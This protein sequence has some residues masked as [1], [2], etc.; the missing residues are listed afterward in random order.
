MNHVPLKLHLFFLLTLA[1]SCLT[2]CRN[3]SRA[4]RQTVLLDQAGGTI[5]FSSGEQV[6]VAAGFFDGPTAVSATLSRD[7]PALG[8]ASTDLTSLRRYSR[9]AAPGVTLEFSADAVAQPTSYLSNRA[10]QVQFPVAEPGD[11]NRETPQAE[12]LLQLADGSEHLYYSPLDDDSRVRLVNG[13][14]LTEE[15]R[16]ARVRLSVSPVRLEP[17]AN[18]ETQALPSG[19]FTEEVAGPFQEGVGFAFAPDERI[20][21]AEKRGVVRVVQGGTLLTAPFIDIAAQ[22]NSQ[23]DRGLLSVA[24]HPDFPATP[25]VYLLHTYEPPQVQGSGPGGADGDGGRVARLVRV[26]A[27][28][29]RNHNVALAGSE[30]ILLG[31]NSSYANIGNPNQRNSAVPS[32]EQDGQ[33][34]RDC[35][36]SDE[37]S[38]TIGSLR[39][40]S[41]GALLVSNGDGANFLAVEPYATRSLEL[42]SLAGKIL[43]IDPLTGRGLADNPFYDGDP[44]SN[45]SK[46]LSLGL[47]NPFRFALQPGTDTPFVGDVGWSTWEEINAG[48]GAN[49]GWPCYEGGVA[50]NLEQGSYRAL[51]R[52][53]Q[54]YTSGGVT[55][56]LYAYPHDGLSASAQVGDFYTGDSY[57]SEYK[58]AL[59]IADYSA[60]WIK[61]L[62]LTPAGE[63]ESVHDFGS[64]PGVVQLTQAP[65]G[66][67]YYMNI[68]E[69]RLKRIRFSSA[70]NAAPSARINADPRKGG[71]PLVVTFSGAASSDPDDDALT[72]SWTFGDGSTATGVSPSHTYTEPGVYTAQLTVTDP[73]TAT[74]TARLTVEV[75]ESPPVATITAPA[76]GARYNVGD[77]VRYNGAGVDPED[78]ALTGAG[79]QWHFLIHHADH[80]HFDALPATSVTPGTFTPPDHG[81]NSYMELCLTVTDS[82]GAQDQDCHELYPNLARYTLQTEPP[83]LSLSWEGRERQTPFSVETPV[84]SKHLLVA[85]TQQGAWTFAGWS[86]GGERLHSLTVE[87]DKTLTARY[88]LNE[89]LLDRTGN[90][91]ETE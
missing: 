7:L 55:A 45:R 52:C 68:V 23:W 41:S 53:Q 13:Q 36:P 76:D 57:P 73:N 77:T 19:F 88:T 4:D 91:C 48:R 69:G 24:V 33:Y 5:S 65:N 81:D 25:Y 32:C 61:Y 43:R 62:R 78:G 2:A 12:V 16:G 14:L 84:G 28:P 9:A 26:S 46:V 70:G 80:L 63:L 30:V 72:Y 10:L 39:F 17:A 21:I 8:A 59:F 54:L 44:N 47:R 71:V 40:S 82:Q 35:L 83:G 87:D 34:V 74:G 64:E 42:D 11:P 37:M 38:H 56:P 67:L 85:P 49:F 18:L 60:Q 31:S 86:D 51:P 27:D 22:T 79:L 75:A 1:L 3:D 29:A 20:F 58:D 6:E 66:D 90:A 15:V 89:C 50:G